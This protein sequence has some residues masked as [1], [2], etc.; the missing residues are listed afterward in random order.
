MYLGVHAESHPDRPAMVM[1]DG[2]GTVTY[3]ELEEASNRFAHG[4]AALGLGPGDVVAVML[5]NSIEWGVAWWGTVRS[6][7]YLTPINWHL[8]PEEVEYI[9]GNSEAK[10]L[11]TG[12]STAEAAARAVRDLPGITLLQVG[13]GTDAGPGVMDFGDFLAEQPGTRIANELAGAPM[14]YSSGTTGRPK[15][16]KARLTGDHPSRVPGVPY[17]MVTNFGMRE[18][19]RYLN[20][21][22]LYHGAP[23]TFSFG[24]HTIGA[25]SVIMRKFDPERALRLLQDERITISQW[26]PTMFQ[27]MLRLPDE[28]KDAYDLS[29]HRVAVHAASPCPPAVKAAMIKWWGPILLE[30]YGASECGATVITSEEWLTRPGSV[31]RPWNAGT[32]MAVLDI[33]SREPVGPGREGLIYFEPLGTHHIEYHKDPEKTASIHHAGMVTAGDI[34]YVDD[35]GYLF[36]TDRL[37]NMIISGGVNIYPQEI[38]FCLG[39]HPSVADVAVFGVPNEEFGE[40]VKAVV[41]VVAGTEVGPELV[42][43]LTSYC[44]AHLAGFKVPRSIEVVEALP[45]DEN[46]KLYKRRL[47]DPYWEGRSS[48]VI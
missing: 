27:R 33:E 41:E 22:P 9:L 35:D 37:S 15:G 6:G 48:Q 10:V 8:V 28:V 7:M 25:T 18:G 2:T 29:A 1:E 46:G 42:A 34:G 47:R 11:V 43:E 13:A 26:V 30:Y 17:L 40:E 14:F 39:E 16:I 38:E 21:A 5:E 44:R 3:G 31:G 45:R 19:D 24:A 20:P 12:S 32:K 23:S 4:L 36:L